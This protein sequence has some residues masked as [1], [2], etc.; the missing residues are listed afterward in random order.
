MA[1]KYIPIKNDQMF[2]RVFGTDRELCRH[3]IELA[4]E[5]PIEKVEFVEAQ[6]ESKDFKRPGGAYFDVL[7]ITEKGE[8]I[9][10]EMQSDSMPGLLQRA[11]LY[12]GRL[13]REAWAR[14]VSEHH[15]YD[16]TKM[17]RVAVIIICDFD[18][19]DDGAKRYTESLYIEG[20]GYV[21]DGATT[22]LLNARGSL[23]NVSPDLAA[24]LDY[25]ASGKFNPG[26]SAFV[27]DVARKVD[28]ANDDAVFLEGL[29]DM[30][31]KLWVSKEEGRQEGKEEGRAE[32]RQE[33]R[34]EG[35]QEG[36]AEGRSE[37]LKEGAEK[38]RKQIAELTNHMIA[39]HRQ[40]E[41]AAVLTDETRLNH[42]LN[43]YGLTN[44]Q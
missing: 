27:D 5:E 2:K 42:E 38:Q 4:L 21:S 7:A 20:V 37:G 22:V 13:T 32:G 15:S 16:Y 8:M 31:E 24:F 43:N 10:V 17:P 35:R 28:V 14:Y 44:V 34:A 36:R 39:D 25:V 11:R 41:L 29:M 9:D 23:N 18:P 3:L 26:E 40:D 6:R 1:Q 33:G 30:D 19:F 12:S